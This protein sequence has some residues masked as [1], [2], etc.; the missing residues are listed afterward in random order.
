MSSPGAPKQA[1]RRL[2][3]HQKLP[4]YQ[5]MS[6]LEPTQFDFQSR[7]SP[8]RFKT[9]NMERYKRVY[10]TL[11]AR[12]RDFFDALPVLFHA[13]HAMLPGYCG[14]NTPCGIS[15]YVPTE[16]ATKAVRRLNRSVEVDKRL[17]RNFTIRGLYM[18][19]SPG[20]IAYSRRSDLDLWVIH[21]PTLDEPAVAALN[22]KAGVIEEFAATLG[23]EVH[24]F[25]FDA[26]RFRSGEDLSLSEESSG[27]SQHYL[28]LDEFYRSSMLVAGL[29]PLWWSVPAAYDRQYDAYLAAAD[30]RG[31][32]DRRNA[33]DFGGLPTIPAD[34]FFGAAVW[35]LYKSIHAPYK[36]VLKL[37]LMEAYAAEYPDITLL[38]TRFKQNV[39]AGD[40]D[41]RAVDPYIL[42]YHKVSEYLESLED[43]VRL[44]VLRRSFYLKTNVA[45]SNR[46][47]FRDDWRTA[48]VKEMTDEWGWDKSQ[49]ERLDQR[50]TWGLDTAV[51]ERRDLSQT[52]KSSY[53]MLS[54]FAKKHAA[55]SKISKRDLHVLGRKLY[56]AFEKKASKIEVVTRGICSKPIEQRLSL[57]EVRI[58]AGK[59]M[60]VLFQGMVTP[61]E[62]GTMKPI[63]RSGSAA[64]IVLWCHLNKLV[65]HATTWHV[66][67]SVSTLS[68]NDIKRMRDVIDQDLLE[69]NAGAADHDDH[70]KRRIARVA[71]LINVGVDPF[72]GSGSGGDILTT[73]AADPLVYGGREMNL[74]RTI[75]MLF[76]T[77]WDEAFAFHYEG[78]KAVL[79]AVA[80]CLQ[81]MASERAG[82][83]LPGVETRC[84]SVNATTQI[85]TRIDD[86]FTGVMD[87]M[88]GCN[89]GQTPN[90]IL[91]SE[92]Q[93]HHLRFVGGRTRVESLDSQAVLLRAL[94]PGDDPNEQIVR[95]DRRCRRAGF[96]PLIYAHNE[97]EKIQVF[98]HRRGPRADVYVLDECGA[99][100][101]HRQECH[102]MAA[103]LQHYR[104]FLDTVLPRCEDRPGTSGELSIETAEVVEENDNWVINPYTP[105]PD[106]TYDYLALHVLADADSSGNQQFTIYTGE[107]EFSTWEHGASLFTQVA[108]Y[109]MGQRR[110]GDVYPIYITDLD[111]STRFRQ[112]VGVEALRPVDLL[113]YKKRIEFQLTRAMYDDQANAQKDRKKDLKIAS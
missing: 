97:A 19:G 88:A 51:E 48:I 18:M 4:L 38:C 37:L 99:L 103:L 2:K 25:V 72:A 40:A 9:L 26:E 54:A 102:T 27:S 1:C 95:F 107:R 16:A 61:T 90:F 39:Q 66:F 45:V 77:S 81:W 58:D 23:L 42:M 73:N 89:R 100:L 98:A 84:F 83:E 59:Y 87:F 52:F 49:I 3:K 8:E 22:R 60:W 112:L 5:G 63:K 108:A 78:P 76:V 86:L 92:G 75:D 15:S 106:N 34:E 105:E 20:T 55:D 53:N 71:L 21:D 82:H 14:K 101:V 110:S 44:E 94:G 12:Q 64:E 13:N 70:E 109:V 50:D 46:T 69:P 93:L 67:T 62:A 113:N 29:P 7:P 10:E 28:L 30:E 33:I 31:L 6:Q 36:S 85:A 74:V 96:L 11:T 57:H 32:I 79:E 68:A 41:L 80:E 17:S 43:T 91:Q 35:H 24:F 111:L 65:D 56:V 104:R 47:R